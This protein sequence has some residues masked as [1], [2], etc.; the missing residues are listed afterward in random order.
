VSGVIQQWYDEKAAARIIG[1]SPRTLRAWRKDGKVSYHR[2]P[3]GRVRY[4]LDQMLDLQRGGM[5]AAKPPIAA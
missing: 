5:V 2:T 3:G 4:T 1:V